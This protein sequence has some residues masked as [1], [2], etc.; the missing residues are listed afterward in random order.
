LIKASVK[1][2]G[3]EKDEYGVP[4]PYHSYLIVS[5]PLQTNGS[6]VATALPLSLE[7]PKPK[8]LHKMV[9]SGGPES[10]YEEMLM[11]LRQLPQNARLQE[12]IDKE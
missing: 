3:I 1:F 6:G 5:S 11:I 7:A 9:A 8:S 10:A 12:R 4:K 2:F